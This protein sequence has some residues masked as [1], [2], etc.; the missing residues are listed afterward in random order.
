MRHIVE[1]GTVDVLV[2]RTA[3]DI[4]LRSTVTVAAHPAYWRG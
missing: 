3:A 1:S 2:G 4:R